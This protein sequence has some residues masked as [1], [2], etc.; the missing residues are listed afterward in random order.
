LCITLHAP[1]INVNK[2]MRIKVYVF[3]VS[4]ILS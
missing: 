1:Q 3:I 2:V 4:G